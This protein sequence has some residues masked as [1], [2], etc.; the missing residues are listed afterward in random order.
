MLKRSGLFLLLLTVACSCRTSQR[1]FSV[2]KLFDETQAATLGLPF[3]P[4]RETFPIFTPDSTGNRYNHGVVLFP[5]QGVLYAQWQS[6]ATDEDGPDTRVFYSCSVDGVHWSAPMALTDSWA[7]GITTSGG[8]WSDGDTL[9]AYL[10]VWP[11]QGDGPKQGHTEYRTSTDG[12]TWSERSPVLD[13]SGKP[14]PGIIEQ[15]V[16][17]LPGGRLLTAFHRQP[18]LIVTPY[19][20]DDP[21]GVAGWTAGGMDHLPAKNSAMSREIEPAWFYRK[22]GAIV[23]V[24]RDQNS[25]FKKLAAVSKDHGRTWTTPELIDTPDSR[26]KQSA[27]NLPDGTAFM[28]SNPSGNK[29]RFPLVITLSDDGF[30]FDRAFLLRAGGADLQPQRF[31]GKYKRVGYS[32]PKSVIWGD[33]LYVGYATNKEDVEVTRVLVRDM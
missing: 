13:A 18:G 17:A 28:V 27:G 31:A 14:V 26:A 32:Y 30:R 2:S 3:A 6:S 4:G 25:T 22:D 19:F 29:D 10:C 1:P 7:G 11:E 12:L 21:L 23:M 33:Y 9:I 24:F 5:F 20:T 15:D 8:W 16:H